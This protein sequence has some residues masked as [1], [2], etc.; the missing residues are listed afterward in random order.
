MLAH[1]SLNEVATLDAERTKVSGISPVI[2]VYLRRGPTC[3]G[4][5]NCTWSCVRGAYRKTHDKCESE[6]LHGPW[7]P[8]FLACSHKGAPKTERKGS[9]AATHTEG[10]C[11]RAPYLRPQR[12]LGGPFDAAVSGLTQPARRRR[13]STPRPGAAPTCPKPRLARLRG[14]FRPIFIG[15]LAPPSAAGGGARSARLKEPD[16]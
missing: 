10:T 2:A 16:Q 14:I 9:P 8:C 13:V 1:T 3:G 7:F 5:S 12:L 11:G 4:G 15:F 6:R